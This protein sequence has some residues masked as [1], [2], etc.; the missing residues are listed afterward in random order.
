[1]RA[2]LIQ[3]TASDDPAANLPGTMAMIAEAAGQGAD[4]VLTPEVTNC[5]SASRTRQE[6]VLQPEDQD[7]TLAAL[8]AQAA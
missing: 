5:V 3:L 7:Q 8:R 1:M 2:G 6:Q 4:L